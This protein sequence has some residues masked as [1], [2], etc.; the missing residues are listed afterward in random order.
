MSF[1]RSTVIDCSVSRKTRERIEN[2]LPSGLPV[3]ELIDGNTRFYIPSFVEFSSSIMGHKAHNVIE[4]PYSLSGDYDFNSDNYVFACPEEDISLCKG[5][6]L[7]YNLCRCYIL[8]GKDSIDQNVVDFS[9]P[10]LLSVTSMSITAINASLRTGDLDAMAH[11]I[12]GLSFS[13]NVDNGLNK[14][15]K[16]AVADYYV[17]A[18]CKVPGAMKDQG[19]NA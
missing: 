5:I 9:H 11:V 4:I 6:S 8:S 15:V 2:A 16:D 3:V 18:I 14:Q 10:Y 12:G 17:H 7:K 13:K 1:E 19:G